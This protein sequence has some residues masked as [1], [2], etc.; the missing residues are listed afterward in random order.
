METN[1]ATQQ[2]FVT[3]EQ[4]NTI[5]TEYEKL[6]QNERDNKIFEAIN[7]VNE[8]VKNLDNKIDSVKTELKTEIDSVKKDVEGVKK[9]VEGVKKDID[10]KF[11]TFKKDI[12]KDTELKNA[13]TKLWLMSTTIS[14]TAII[15]LL[16]TAF[17]FW[18]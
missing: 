3:I 6:K 4:F 2:Q 1:K 13:Q 9:D 7:K 5:I 11:E 16:M 8:S 10:I 15:G 14:C 18:H 17:K 12:S